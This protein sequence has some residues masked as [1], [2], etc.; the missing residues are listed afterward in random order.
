MIWRWLISYCQTLI[1]STFCECVM[2]FSLG[3]AHQRPYLRQVTLVLK[4]HFD[5]LLKNRTVEFRLHMF[6]LD[7]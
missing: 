4:T 3:H 1:A 5:G 2:A 6:D 7:G